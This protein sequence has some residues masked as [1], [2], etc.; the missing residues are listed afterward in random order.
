MIPPH[1]PEPRIYARSE[2]GLSRSKIDKNALKVLYRLHQAGYQAHMVGGAPRDL[3]LGRVPK[4]YDIATDARPVQ[5]RRLFKNS[6]IIGRR[7]RL[8]HIYFREGIVEVATFRKAPDPQVQNVAAGELL[9]TDD[10]VFGSPAD[11][12]LRRD[13]T[14]NA[15]FYNIADYSV[16]DYVDGIHDLERSVIRVIGDPDVRFR[17][18]PIRMTR[19]CELAARL[20]FTIDPATQ[21]GILRH[22][23]EIDKAAPARLVE[24]IG[25]IFR[26]G[27]AGQAAQ[28]MQELGLLTA[29]FPE[30][31]GIEKARKAGRGDFSTVF[32]VMDERVAAGQAPSEIGIMAS[33]VLPRVIAQRRDFFHE[34]AK[35]SLLREAI[36][37]EA[38]PLLRRLALAKHKVEFVAQSVLALRQLKMRR[39][40][41]ADRV[42]FSRRSFFEDALLVYEIWIRATGSDASEIKRW[43][44][45]AKARADT[46]SRRPTRKTRRGRRTKKSGRPGGR[47]PRLK[48]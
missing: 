19:A 23:G 29:L 7:F 20:G 10:N 36:V 30:I 34:K 11:D 9:I 27:R 40:Q 47:P 8:A 15:L 25:Q 35:T 28:W 46:V 43:R 13:F 14:V 21:E 39:W 22:A 4:D 24:E 16:V 32:G 44:R 48:R 45:V 2:H 41:T 1:W 6:R 3:L 18:D 5:V 42:S 31:R 12:A 38:A 26:C 37:E 17:E 33:L